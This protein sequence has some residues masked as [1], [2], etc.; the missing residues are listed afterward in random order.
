M[1]DKDEWGTPLELFYKLDREFHF[2]WDV[3]AEHYNAKCPGYY[4]PADDGLAQD[5]SRLAP[6]WYWMNPPYSNIKK[7]MHKAHNYVQNHNGSV[8]VLTA[9]RTDTRWWWSYA[10]HYHIRLLPGRLRFV[11]EDGSERV[12]APF[13]SAIIL[14]QPPTAD[15]RPAVHWWDWKKNEY[16]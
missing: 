4:S 6:G 14:M 2:V 12:G 13:P 10:I 8:C 9:A 15:Y 7:W 16:R 11:Q 1:S 5:W 3:C